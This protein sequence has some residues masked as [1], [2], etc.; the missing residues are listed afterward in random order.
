MAGDLILVVDDTPA[1]LRLAEFLLARAG[2]DVRT[3]LD[4]TEARAAV[5]DALPALILMDLQ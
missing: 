1:Y 4:A 2:F 5:R 3:A